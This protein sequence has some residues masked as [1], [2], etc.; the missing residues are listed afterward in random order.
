MVI[1]FYLHFVNENAGINPRK[2]AH[3]NVLV[4]IAFYLLDYAKD[5]FSLLKS[6]LGPCHCNTLSFVLHPSRFYFVIELKKE[7]NVLR[8]RVTYTLVAVFL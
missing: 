7:E 2:Q 8:P 4:L 1:V 5:P 3:V 6:L